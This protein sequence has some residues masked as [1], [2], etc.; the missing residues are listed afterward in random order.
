M[1][2]TIQQMRPAA[3]PECCID[4]TGDSDDEQVSV[5]VAF[6]TFQEVAHDS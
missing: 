5:C 2:F 4:L 6:Q 1:A 3:P